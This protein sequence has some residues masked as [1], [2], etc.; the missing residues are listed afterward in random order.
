VWRTESRLTP[1]HGAIAAILLVALAYRIFALTGDMFF[2]PTI[3]AQ[4]AFN[5]LQGTFTLNTDSWY[6]HRLP[7]FV[8]IAP[9]YAVFGV[10]PATSR[11]WPLLLSLVQV[12]LVIWLGRRLFDRPT[13]ILA[14]VLVAVTPLDAVYGSVLQPDTIMAA[15]L[16][17]AAGLWI[18]SLEQ[19]PRHPRVYPFLSGVCFALAVV[20]RENA[21]LL[22]V[23]YVSSILWRRPRARALLDAMLDT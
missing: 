21:A 9:L 7:V 13:A 1:Y 17:A 11:L 16:T 18:A 4:N 23:F 20:T 3:Y 10:G 15:F 14:G 5:L 22:L 19:D 6:A 2:D 8:P 12:A